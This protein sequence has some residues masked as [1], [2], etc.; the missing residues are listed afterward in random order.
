MSHSQDRQEWENIPLRQRIARLLLVLSE[1]TD[2]GEPSEATFRAVDEGVGAF[3]GPP[4]LGLKLANRPQKA[5]EF[6]E[7]ISRYSAERHGFNPR[8]GANAESGIAYS[9]GVG[10][11]DVPYPAVLGEQGEEAAEA[12]GYQVGCD[13]A[14]HGYTWCF[15]PIADVRTSS[16]DPV[17]GVRAFGSDPFLV[18][19]HSAAFARGVQSAGVLACVK[20]FPGHG[21]ASTDS[22]LDLPTVSRTEEEHRRVHI[23]PFEKVIS[24]GVGSVMTAHVVLPEQGQKEV[25][26]FSRD[27]ITSLLREE[28]GFSGIVVTDSLRMQA[29]SDRF[30]SAEA[31]IRA[32]KAGNDIANIKCRPAR[33]PA[34]LDELEKAVETGQVGLDR[35]WQAYNRV[36]SVQESATLGQA[37][38]STSYDAA[39]LVNADLPRPRV[40]KGATVTVAI[41]PRGGDTEPPQNALSDVGEKLGVRLL[42]SEEPVPGSRAH[43]V[44]CRAQGG[45]SEGEK[46]LI[47]KAEKA[48]VPA[49]VF[50]GGPRS[51]AHSLDSPLPAVS[52]PCIDVFAILSR[53]TALQGFAA[54]LEIVQ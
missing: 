31:V 41:E 26:T 29:V 43:I 51:T 39:R 4:F 15:Q 34:L 28:L 50:L 14:E 3:H 8:I 7:R 16:R 48:Q 53:P 36:V 37:P 21:D 27:M 20:H 22:H 33:V 38:T 11:T 42:A 49:A 9:I 5:L 35:L 18:G 40:P 2:S 6:N 17:I 19:Q 54:I 23:P 30:S 24:A 10:G 52:A 44:L 47:A 1:A 25:A 45:I 12:A 46:R 13:L 32:L